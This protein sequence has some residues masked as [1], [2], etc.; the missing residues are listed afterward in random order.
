VGAAS[1]GINPGRNEERFGFGD[2]FAEKI[3]QPDEYSDSK[4]LKK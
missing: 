2:R 4:C 1:E 3:K